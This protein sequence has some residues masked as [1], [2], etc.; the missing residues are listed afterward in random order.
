MKAG[1]SRITINPAI[2]TRMAG[3]GTRDREKGCVGIHD[4]INAQALYLKV[5]F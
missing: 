5:D 3:F 2:G 1:H 4:G